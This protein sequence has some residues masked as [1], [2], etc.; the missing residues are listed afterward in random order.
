MEDASWQRLV[1]SDVGSACHPG[2]ILAVFC[3]QSGMFFTRS[4]DSPAF[5]D[6]MQIRV[7]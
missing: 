3:S 4:I 1:R 2:N 5:K 7:I 6:F